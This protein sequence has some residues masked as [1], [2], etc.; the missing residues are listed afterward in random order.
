VIEQGDGSVRVRV[1]A[2]A[3]ASRTEIVGEHNG[4]LKVR[5][6]APPVDGAANDELVRHLA[7]RVGVAP[8][9]VRVLSGGTG[10]SK[11]IQIDGVDAAAVRMAL[12]E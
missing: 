11:V 10:R 3:R 12:L 4:A 1:H 7:R 2:Q 8:S 9:R 6:A 5:I